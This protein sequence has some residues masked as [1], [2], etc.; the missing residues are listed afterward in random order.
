MIAKVSAITA[1]LRHC[2]SGPLWG[3]YAVRD[4]HL[5]TGQN[6][7]SSGLVAQPLV[8]ALQGT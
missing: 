1:L 4:G 3:A 8:A 5:I 7:A 2:E 6:P